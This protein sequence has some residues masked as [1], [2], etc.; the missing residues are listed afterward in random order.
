[1]KHGSYLESKVLTAPPHRLHLIL[2]EGAIRFGRQAEE[3]L[4]RKDTI[5]AAAPLRRVIDIVGEMLAGVRQN[6]SELNQKLAEVY[7]FIFRRVSEAKINSD[8]TALAQSL[9]LLDY[10]RE[11]WQL[12]CDK[13]G[14]G[15][16]FQVPAPILNG[17]GPS[18]KLLPNSGISFE[19]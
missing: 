14:N 2:I 16:A 5:G 6:K 8:C 18:Q 1:M 10:E 15:S 12:A 17:L 4:N 11:T 3:A 7:W 19:A 9:Q 13:L